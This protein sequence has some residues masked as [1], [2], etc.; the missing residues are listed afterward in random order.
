MTYQFQSSPPEAHVGNSL[1][2]IDSP[3]TLSSDQKI[4]AAFRAFVES[5]EGSALTGEL[6]D[7]SQVIVLGQTADPEGR[8]ANV[9]GLSGQ[10]LIET[11]E[12]AGSWPAYADAASVQP[13]TIRRADPEIAARIANRDN[14]F[15]NPEEF[16]KWVI[17]EAPRT[18]DAHLEYPDFS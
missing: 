18:S 14:Q 17:N 2:D 12:A 6:G 7:K 13:T 9:F 3:K 10:G 4:G 15:Q 11:H 16:M 1:K 5:D 8:Y